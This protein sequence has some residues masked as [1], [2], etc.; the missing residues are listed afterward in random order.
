MDPAELVEVAEEYAIGVFP[1]RRFRRFTHIEI[2]LETLVTCPWWSLRFPDAP[3]EVLLQRR[4][5]GATFSAAACS[6]TG[7]R[8]DGREVDQAGLIWL[9]DGHGWGLETVL[10]EL[11][12]LAAGPVSGHGPE[13]REALGELWRHEAGIEA[14]VAL[15]QGYSAAGLS[16]CGH[17]AAEQRGGYPRPQPHPLSPEL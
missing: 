4:S 6:D 7:R 3:L 12:H 9:V 13:F 15:Q 16:A 17:P 5:A 14:W 2:Y 8:V 11:A 10:H 1:L